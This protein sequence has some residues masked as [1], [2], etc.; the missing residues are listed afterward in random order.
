MKV[1]L[2]RLMQVQLLKV[3]YDSRVFGMPSDEL[4]SVKDSNGSTKLIPQDLKVNM[5]SSLL[6]RLPFISLTSLVYSKLMVLLVFKSI[7]IF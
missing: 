7:S 6:S 3:A 5:I 1:N 4:Q 2:V